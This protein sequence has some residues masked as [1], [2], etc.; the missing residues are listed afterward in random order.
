M[1]YEGSTVYG[2]PELGVKKISQDIQSL[3]KAATF[4]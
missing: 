4:H 2:G 1:S 3:G